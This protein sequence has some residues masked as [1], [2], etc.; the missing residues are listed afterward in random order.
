MD[1]MAAATFIQSLEQEGASPAM[2]AAVRFGDKELGLKGFWTAWLRFRRKS[3]VAG[4]ED[5][6]P[7]ACIYTLAG[8]NEEALKWLEKAF[9]ARRPWILYIG[10]DPIFD[11]LRS[12]PRFASL[13]RRIGLPKPT[14]K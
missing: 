11:S 7:I 2:I 9:K 14:K 6:M 3:I 12:D 4:N 8:D 13:S 10:V 1:S 5:P